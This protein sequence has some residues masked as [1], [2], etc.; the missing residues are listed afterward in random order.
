MVATLAR[1]QTPTLSL[2][3]TEINSSEVPTGPSASLTV[4]PG[5][6]L[7]VKI[8]LRDWSPAGQ[9]LRGY[10]VNLDPSSFESGLAGYVEPVQY[11]ALSAADA[12]NEDNAFIDQEDPDFIFFGLHPLAIM[13]TKSPGYRWMAALI[14][15]GLPSPQDGT[16]FAVG[17]VYLQVSDDAEGTFTISIRTEPSFTQLRD[18]EKELILPLEAEPL[19]LT[20]GAGAVLPAIESSDPPNGY[21]DATIPASFAGGRRETIIKLIF[22]GSAEQVGVG[23]FTVH[24]GT[25]APP[26]ILRVKTEGNTAAVVLDRAI[27]PGA[28]TTITHNAS[29]SSTRIGS[30]P[31]DVNGDGVS[32]ALDVFALVDVLN[33]VSELPASRTDVDRDGVASAPDVLQVL[34]LIMRRTPDGGGLP[35][36]LPK[37]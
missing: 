31:G 30:L 25:E 2:E 35:R 29:G 3:A 37:P 34:E 24:D 9:V 14:Q 19:T 12:A 11:R 23:D 28:W 5:D 32:D 36:T 20:V 10:Q 16:R 26:G 15:G 17:D 13:D 21:V 18:M 33:G 8:R 22:N 6:I 27:T 4:K 1:G 7:R